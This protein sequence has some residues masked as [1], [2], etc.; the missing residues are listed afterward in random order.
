MS[1][2]DFTLA[3]AQIKNANQNGFIAFYNK[4][5]HYNYVRAKY[6]FPNIV[7]CR[8]FLKKVYLYDYLHIAELEKITSVEKWMSL[9]V[10]CCYH[11]ILVENGIDAFSDIPCDTSI[12]TGLP[13]ADK[14]IVHCLDKKSSADYL[15]KQ[16]KSLP[17]LPRILFSCFYHDG[18]SAD[19]IAQAFSCTK[20]T[21]LWELGKTRDVLFHA[22]K[23]EE[24]TLGKP[25]YPFNL[26]LVYESLE[27]ENQKYYST[28]E[29]AL[30]V[31]ESISAELTF[32]KPKKKKVLTLP[33]ICCFSLLILALVVLHMYSG[34]S[35]K[36][37]AN[38]STGNAILENTESTGS[39]HSAPKEDL[40]PS[41][42]TTIR[43]ENGNITT[44]DENGSEIPTPSNHA[45]ELAP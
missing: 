7:E 2:Q 6:L 12:S 27:L 23:Q 1:D 18:L 20:E 42:T 9:N 4:T 40:T 25:L 32:R 30:L 33:L 34:S 14:P 21:V 5:F 13:E 15:M 16:F 41:S 19:E 38:P 35:N 17:V 24:K 36:K 31:W 22:Y 39:S 28:K 37:T 3:I 29:F 43:D 11:D 10:L 44:Y 45:S 8:E 26:Q